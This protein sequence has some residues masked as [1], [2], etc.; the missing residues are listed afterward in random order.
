MD[1]EYGLIKLKKKAQFNGRHSDLKFNNPDFELLAKAFG[2]CG[3]TL[4]APNQVAPALEE[5]FSQNGPAN[6]AIPVDYGEN[7]KLTECPGNI[8]IFI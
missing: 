6:I 2:V 1:G 8:S 3:S 5:E 7:M 4:G